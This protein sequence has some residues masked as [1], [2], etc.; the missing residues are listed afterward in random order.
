MSTYTFAVGTVLFAV[1]LYFRCYVVLLL[2]CSLWWLFGLFLAYVFDNWQFDAFTAVEPFQTHL[3]W[4]IE[5]LCTQAWMSNLAYMQ[6]K[7]VFTSSIDMLRHMASD[8]RY[9]TCFGTCA[10]IAGTVHAYTCT[11]AYYFMYSTTFTVCAAIIG[12]F[13][14]PCMDL[15]VIPP[16]IIAVVDG[17]LH[18][19]LP[20]CVHQ[21]FCYATLQ[22]T[23]MQA[24]CASS[25]QRMWCERAS[26]LPYPPYPHDI[27]VNT[28]AHRCCPCW[29]RCRKTMQGVHI[30]TVLWSVYGGPTYR[31]MHF[32]DRKRFRIEKD[33]RCSTNKQHAHRASGCWEEHLQKDAQQR[34]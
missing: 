5:L 12:A 6:S 17:N 22:A 20:L 13:L 2:V 31:H 9:S 10:V 19:V 11:A 25:I 23:C 18:F 4:T 27:T 7:A 32:Q 24:A 28:A 29:T 1:W 3:S 8:C 16:Y 33:F 21:Q 26:M 14:V 15:W 30:T 34:Q